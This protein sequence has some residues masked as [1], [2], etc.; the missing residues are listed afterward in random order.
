MSG[1]PNATNWNIENGFALNIDENEIYPHRVF[2]C[3]LHDSLIAILNIL[4]DDAGNFCSQLAQGFR[5]SLHSPDELPKLPDEFIFIPPEQDV[6]ISVKP[7]MITTSKGLRYYSADLRGCYFKAD[8]Q[9]RFFQS[10]SQQHCELECLSNFTNA[11]CGC[12]GI[13]TPSKHLK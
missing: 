4:L 9:L 2:D 3:G 7:Q 6:Y 10:Y 8:R 13:S 12:V 1:Y 5:L 11:A